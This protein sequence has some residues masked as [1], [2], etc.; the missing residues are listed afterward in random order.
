[1]AGRAADE[2]LE[3]E[4][5]DGRSSPAVD[6]GDPRGLLPCWMLWPGI[7]CELYAACGCTAATG[8]EA[9]ELLLANDARDP[10][11]AKPNRPA[12]K[13]LPVGAGLTLRLLLR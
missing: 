1:M 12:D 13:G 3:L 5:V 11:A 8:D 7:S 4:L 9:T 10:C 2:Q 6:G